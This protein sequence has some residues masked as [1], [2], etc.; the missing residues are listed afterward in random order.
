MK[1]TRNDL[2]EPD[3]A[4]QTALKLLAPLAKKS[5]DTNCP[6]RPVK[7]SPLGLVL[8]RAFL[9]RIA[10]WTSAT[11]FGLHT[12]DLALRFWD[13]GAANLQHGQFYMSLMAWFF[14]L[15]FFVLWWRLK[16]DFL[17]MITAPLALILFTSSAIYL[18]NNLVLIKFISFFSKTCSQMKEI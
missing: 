14:V 17:S 2:P 11:A 18:R 15:I 16:H 12:V 5:R 8:R 10:A 6:L 7:I 1:L 9:K 4:Q 13:L 3:V